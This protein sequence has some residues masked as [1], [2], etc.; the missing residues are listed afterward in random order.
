LCRYNSDVRVVDGREPGSKVVEFAVTNTHAVRS[1]SETA[2]VYLGYPASAGEPPKQLRG[3]AKLS[4]EPGQTRQLRMAGG[5]YRLR[6]HWS[7]HYL[8][9]AWFQPLEPIK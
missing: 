6:T 4:Y 8:G 7:H 2:Q 5:L 9:T 1:G 3:F